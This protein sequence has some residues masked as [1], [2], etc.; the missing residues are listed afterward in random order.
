MK[1]IDESGSV[2][3]STGKDTENISGVIAIANVSSL[4]SEDQSLN[5]DSLTK[6]CKQTLNDDKKTSGVTEQVL[7][8][9]GSILPLGD[10]SKVGE[11]H[12]PPDSDHSTVAKVENTLVQS[13]DANSEINRKSSKF[14]IHGKPLQALELFE[15]RLIIL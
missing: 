15:V 10:E 2:N 5:D 8:I 11:L 4:P 12:Q 1:I 14:S 13:V 3:S 6:S 7:I 9:R